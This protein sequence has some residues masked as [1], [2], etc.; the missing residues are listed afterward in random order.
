MLFNVDLSI[1]STIEPCLF[2]QTIKHK[3]WQ[4]AMR[5]KYDALM[6]NNTW[7]LVNCP[8]N[9]NVVGSKWIYRVKK[10]SDCTIDRYKARLVAKG[11][12]QEEGVDYF[13]TFS[14]VI[15]PTTIRLVLSTALS[16]G[17]YIR[18]LDINN[19]FLNGDLSEVVYMKQPRGFEDPNHPNHVCRLNKVVYSLKQAP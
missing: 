14:P 3:C 5:A 17:W 15:K 2:S 1:S 8:T 16:Q 19:A 9:A 12:S 13:D 4:D 18:Q 7:S 11:F 10:R 6:K